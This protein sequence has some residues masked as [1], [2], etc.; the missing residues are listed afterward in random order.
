MGYLLPALTEAKFD[1]QRDVVLNER[2]QNYENR[3]YGMAPMAIARGA[4]PAGSSVPLADDRQRRRPAR[5]APRRVRD[6]FRPLLPSRATRRWRW[7]ATST[8]TRRSRWCERVLRRHRRRARRSSRCARAGSPAAARCGWSS[9]TASSCRASTSP[10]TR[11][12]SSRRATPSW[13]WWRTCWPRARVSRLYRRLVYERAAWRPTSRPCSSRASCAASSRWSR[14]RRRAT[15]SPS[16]TSRSTAEID[17]LAA[18][19]P[20]DDGTRAQP[21]AGRGAV[22]LPAADGRRLRR[23]VRSAERV[24]RVPRRS[25]LLRAR[26][27][28][29]PRAPRRRRCSA[30]AARVLGRAPRVALSVVPR[31]RLDLALP[32]SAKVVCS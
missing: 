8:P 22:R 32:G 5:R 15:R 19:G 3:P 7:P 28:T 16:W 26:P 29:V 23:Q 24:Q 13:T 4:V 10:G 21:R 30:A 12:R 20:T 1:N 25:R 27:R 6:F 18:G 14:P 17:A 2:R 31:G 11:R 9:R